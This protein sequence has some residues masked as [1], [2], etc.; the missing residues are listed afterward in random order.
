MRPTTRPA[1]DDDGDGVLPDRWAQGG[2][3]RSFV[4]EHDYGDRK[5]V[6]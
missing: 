3:R 6:V 1:R 2:N 4:A 5:S